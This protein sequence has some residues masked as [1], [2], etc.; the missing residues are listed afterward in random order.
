MESCNLRN[1]VKSVAGSADDSSVLKA[2]AD[3]IASA[4]V[5]VDAFKSALESGI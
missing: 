4:G 2:L 1:S 3:L 5:L